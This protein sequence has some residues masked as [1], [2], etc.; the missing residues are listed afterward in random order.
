[1]IRISIDKEDTGLLGNLALNLRQAGYTTTSLHDGLS[2]EAWLAK[3]ETTVQVLH[4]AK[5]NSAPA[6]TSKSKAAPQSANT[7]NC[8][9]LNASQLELTVPD[10]RQ[11]PLSHDVCCILRI[12]AHAN[13]E[14]ISRKMLIEAM[15]HNFLN[16]DERRLE[17]LISRLR[18]KLAAYSP[19]GFLIRAI[20]GHGYLFGVNLQ[21]ME[22][23]Q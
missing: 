13:G 9:K 16:Y 8:W 2:L 15:G 12:V 21:E 20:K 22:S 11:I 6:A 18:R 10:G 5:N 3:Q 14:L 17:A 1:M 23:E 7:Q 4:R 19:E